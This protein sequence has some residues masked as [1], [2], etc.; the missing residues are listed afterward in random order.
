[1]GNDKV[2]TTN[3]DQA[4]DTKVGE[5]IL[6]ADCEREQMKSEDKNAN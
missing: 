2:T 3:S 6:K 1:M 5:E 4:D